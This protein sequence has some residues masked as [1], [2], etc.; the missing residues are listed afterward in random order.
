[1]NIYELQRYKVT[2]GDGESTWEEPDKNGDYVRWDDLHKL[3]GYPPQ[4]NPLL[5]HVLDQL[6]GPREHFRKTLQD[7]DRLLQQ[8]C[9]YA[10][11]MGK[12]Q[13]VPPWYIIGKITSHGSVVSSAIY[14]LY[15][16][17]DD[18]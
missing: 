16:R 4:Q 17:R 8:M 3:A 11:Y 2:N 12:K 13:G 9:S 14:E 18:G 6:A 1:M 7:K 15:R 10:E 5:D